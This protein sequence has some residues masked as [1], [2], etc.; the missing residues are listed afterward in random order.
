MWP[1][2]SLKISSVKGCPETLSPPLLR[3]KTAHY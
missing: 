2:P 3:H 1:V